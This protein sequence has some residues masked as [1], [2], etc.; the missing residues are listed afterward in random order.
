[1]AGEVAA[2]LSPIEDKLVSLTWDVVESF[3]LDWTVTPHR[4]HY[5]SD[6]SAE[7]ATRMDHCFGESLSKVQTDDLENRRCACGDAKRVHLDFPVYSNPVAHHLR[8]DIV[9][10]ADDPDSPYLWVCEVKSGSTDRSG[11][12][13]SKVRRWMNSDPP[14][15]LF[16]C[17]LDLRIVRSR[18]PEPWRG[19][20]VDGSFRR[21]Q[22]ET[23][24]PGAR[25][26]RNHGES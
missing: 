20:K 13:E 21:Y 2:K 7:I 6:I 5:E 18:E 16:G 3:V 10:V 17:V 1:M 22:A 14:L 25:L 4:W 24:P 11:N 8:G 15:V 12:D 23:Y 26:R 19:P 9:M